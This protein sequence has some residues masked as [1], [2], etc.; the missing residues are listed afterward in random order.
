MKKG[1][2]VKGLVITLIAALLFC[3]AVYAYQTFWSG[4]VNIT[5]EPPSGEASVEISEVVVDKGT[6]D[7]TTNTWTVSIARG[8][9]VHLTIYLVNTGGDISE[10]HASIDGDET[11]N[12]YIAPGVRIQYYGPGL[13][14][15][16][17]EEGYI[18]FSIVAEAEAQP[19]TLPE[20]QL[21]LSR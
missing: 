17:G 2:L 18:T 19:G 10:I 8:E 20:I 15:A 14:M 3:G 1:L 4:K 16:A 13:T 9:W 7:E 21:G 6:W 12:R 11:S 5:I